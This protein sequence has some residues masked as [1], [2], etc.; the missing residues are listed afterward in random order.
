[1][2]GQCANVSLFC[3]KN[4]LKP[5]S[6]LRNGSSSDCNV[7]CIQMPSLYN[8][9]Y[10]SFISALIPNTLSLA[11]IQLNKKEVWLF[12]STQCHRGVQGA[13][14]EFWGDW[15]NKKLGGSMDIWTFLQP[16]KKNLKF[17]VRYWTDKSGRYDCTYSGLI[18]TRISGW[19]GLQSQWVCW[20][21]R[22][23]TG[24]TR[25]GE[26]RRRRT[27]LI[28]RFRFP[29]LTPPLQSQATP[30]NSRD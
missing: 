8:T 25:P 14:M 1:L 11:I 15:L 17:R 20:H 27:K 24:C 30:L 7:H 3:S 18:L 21:N 16:T 6:R 4:H 23:R 12:A 28:F 13:W 19:C 2:K 29:P 5:L 10:R 26:R 22:R 9:V